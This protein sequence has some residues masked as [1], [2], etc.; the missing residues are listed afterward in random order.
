MITA[1][2]LGDV[3]PHGF[4]DARAV[5]HRN[6][7]GPARVF[8]FAYV[9]VVIVQRTGVQSNANFVR[10]GIAGI[11]QICPLQALEASPGRAKLNSF[12]NAASYT[13][14]SHATVLLTCFARA[15]IIRS[16][17]SGR[18]EFK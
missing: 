7:A 8:A 15:I 6:Q 1:R 14:T 4:H 13:K 10:R 9:I 18:E 16:N 3:A 17:L 12:H 11:W 5:R 2:K